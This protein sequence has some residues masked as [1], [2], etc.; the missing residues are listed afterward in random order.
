[1]NLIIFLVGCIVLAEAEMPTLMKLNFYVE[2]LCPDCIALFDPSFRIAVNAKGIE[3]MA[4]ITV[5]NFGNGKRN[6]S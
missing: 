1:M 3:K 5:F 4:N 2:S 6:G